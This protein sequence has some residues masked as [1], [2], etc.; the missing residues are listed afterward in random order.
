MCIVAFQK[1]KTNLLSK[2]VL[3][4]EQQP[5]ILSVSATALT[6]FI[7]YIWFF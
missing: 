6:W 4:A 7:R 2:R 1:D 3:D 5:A